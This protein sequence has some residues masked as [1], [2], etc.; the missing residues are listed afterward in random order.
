MNRA[1]KIARKFRLTIAEADAL[2]AAGL[3]TPA[4]IKAQAR[5]RRELPTGLSAKLNRWRNAKTPE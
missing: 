3:D 4:K 5:A 2:I 1:S